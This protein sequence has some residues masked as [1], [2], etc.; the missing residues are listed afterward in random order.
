MKYIF[1]LVAL[2]YASSPALAEEDEIKKGYVFIVPAGISL[3]VENEEPIRN[4][5]QHWFEHSQ[6]CGT[7]DGGKLEV[8]ELLGENVRV[9]Y[10]FFQSE[11][12]NLN[13][14]DRTISTENTE[15]LREKAWVYSDSQRRE[16]EKRKKR[17]SMH[18]IFPHR[19]E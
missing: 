15:N 13:C 8:L 5:G 14:P 4:D 10:R 19:G 2:L 16:W 7:R 18:R 9:E 6:R 11:T 1:A 17:P 3:I 12:V